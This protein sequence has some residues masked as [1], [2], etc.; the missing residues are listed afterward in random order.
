MTGGLVVVVGMSWVVVMVQVRGK[1]WWCAAR[2]AVRRAMVGK[3]EGGEDGESELSAGT[4]LDPLDVPCHSDLYSSL[5]VIARRRIE[6]CSGGC[7][8]IY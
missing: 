4:R 6:L 7:T 5:H 1:W 8:L 3:S 2:S